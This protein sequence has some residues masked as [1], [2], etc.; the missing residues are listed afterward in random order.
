M[1]SDETKLSNLIDKDSIHIFVEGGVI[2]DICGIPKGEKVIVVDWDTEGV[3]PKELTQLEAGEAIVSTWR[4]E[5]IYP[6]QVIDLLKLKEYMKSRD[7]LECYVKL[8]HRLKSSKTII[9][10]DTDSENILVLNEIDGT[11]DEFKSLDDMAEYHK[12]IH[13]A[14][15]KK[16]FYVYGYE[17]SEDENEGI[18]DENN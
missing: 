2:H 13:E 12:T 5:S 6:N 15:A 17:L 1:K 16:A 8:S 10:P 3:E 14:L 9:K 7:Y 11:E 4:G 18:N